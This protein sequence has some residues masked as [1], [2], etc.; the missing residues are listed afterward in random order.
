HTAEITGAFKLLKDAGI[1]AAALIGSE[2]TSH[3][4]F[5]EI[6]DV[7]LSFGVGLT[8]YTG[9]LAL[10][11]LAHPAI[12][13]IVLHLDYG[14]LGAELAWQKLADNPI[15]SNRYMKRSTKLLEAGKHLHLR[16]NFSDP[17]LV[18]TKLVMNVFD[19]LPTNLHSVTRVKYSFS[20]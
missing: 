17:T 9:G 7:T 13:G 20:A 11:Q 15:P 3:S 19:K 18:E 12:T 1:R 2:P 5:E 8:V 6:L 16:I 10:K 14:R 4:Q